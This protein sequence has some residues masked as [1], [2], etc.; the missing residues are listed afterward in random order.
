MDYES[1]ALT[2]EL[3]A[4]DPSGREMIENTIPLSSVHSPGTGQR[5]G[6][7]RN[8]T[9]FGPA[10][11]WLIH[12]SCSVAQVRFTHDVISVKDGACPV[13]ADGHGN[14]LGDTTAHHC[15][16]SGSAPVME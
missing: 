1:T 12:F 15:T 13:T 11:C 10:S 4:R 3:R 14:T 7:D 2:A 9:D 8:G 6:R 5:R 16:H